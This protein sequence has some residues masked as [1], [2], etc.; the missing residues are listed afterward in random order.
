MCGHALCGA[1]V[2]NYLEAAANA[3]H[4]D[5]LS[6]KGGLPGA[7]YFSTPEF[8]VASGTPGSLWGTIQGAGLDL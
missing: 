1:A 5:L 3:E 4:E 8:V 2:E 6:N 7:H